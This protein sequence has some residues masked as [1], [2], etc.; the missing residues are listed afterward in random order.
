MAVRLVEEAQ[1]E[2]SSQWATIQSVSQKNREKYA[3]R[4][5]AKVAVFAYIEGFY[6]PY[7]AG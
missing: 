5:E 1:Q 4:K 7:R 6:D 2:H 3:T